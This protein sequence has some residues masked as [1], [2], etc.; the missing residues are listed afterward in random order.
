LSHPCN[1]CR[2][3][4]TKLKKEFPDAFPETLNLR[5]D[6]GTQN[7][8][9]RCG[10][11]LTHMRRIANPKDDSRWKQCTNCLQDFETTALEKIVLPLK[12]T[13]DR[14][15]SIA[16][17]HSGVSSDTPRK[18]LARESSD[19][20]QV[21]CDSHGI[22]KCPEIPET[23]RHL[24]RHHSGESAFSFDSEGIPKCPVVD[25]PLL[26]PKKALAV[27][28]RPAS[29]MQ[30]PNKANAKAA[31]PK[32]NGKAKAK[33][34]PTAVAKSFAKPANALKLRPHGCSKCRKR[35][36]CTNSCWLQRG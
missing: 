26:L 4:F 12:D 2:N 8:A 16:R 5:G 32:A 34:K 36:G 3:A 22:P 10:V 23:S 14:S 35:P 20:S 13:I 11:M 21:S 17:M 25:F 30:E 24:A 9:E 1:N 18:S 6:N 19:T 29:A 27:L 15:C 28:K 7:L 31:A 33:A